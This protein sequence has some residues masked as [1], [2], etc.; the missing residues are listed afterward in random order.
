M[1]SPSIRVL[2]GLLASVPAAALAQKPAFPPVRPVGPITNVSRDSLASI[3]SAIPLANGRVYVNDIA[4]HRVLLFDSTLSSMTV[5]ADSIG[6]SANAYG[7]RPAAILPFHGDSVLLTSPG[8]ASVQVLTPSGTFGRTIAMPPSTNGLLGVVGGGGVDAN[9]RLLYVMLAK[10][11]TMVPLPPGDTGS[12]TMTTPDSSFVVR[13]DL[14][15]R[16][17]D[18]VTVIRVPHNRTT[19]NRGPR[20]FASALTAYP[21][22]IVDDWTVLPGGGLAVVRGRDYHIEWMSPDGHWT[23]TPRTPFT[24]Q[25]L[26]DTEKRRLI[27]STVTRLQFWNDSMMDAMAAKMGAANGRGGRG[28]ATVNHPTFLPSDVADVP[29]YR[30]AILASGA[31]RADADG[32]LWVFTSAP[33]IDRRVVYD[34]VNQ[35]G[36]LVDRVQLPRNRAL[37][38]FGPGVI[39]MSVLDS[40][41]VAH[42]ERARVK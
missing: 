42:L 12:V 31:V 9:G 13:W 11:P 37:A 26:D 40:N 15:L 41:K 16:K 32:N 6:G 3:F 4:A 38:G 35:E 20:G 30:P 24:W 17:L 22:Q 29:D 18:T 2:V 23:S 10:L 39:Y 5:V 19:I 33:T 7:N 25:H 8:T 34:V 1:P 36:E 21:F 28:A 27:D 14:G